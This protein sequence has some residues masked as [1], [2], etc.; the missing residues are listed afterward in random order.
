M[1]V[2]EPFGVAFALSRGREAAAVV[3]VSLPVHGLPLLQKSHPGK[4]PVPLSIGTVCTRALMTNFLI[5]ALC[6]R[7]QRHCA[8]R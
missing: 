2:S 3:L 4:F 6:R 1:T 7:A 5:P 8:L